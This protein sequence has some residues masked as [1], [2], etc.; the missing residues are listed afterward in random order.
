[1]GVL[2]LLAVL[3]QFADLRINLKFEIEVLCKALGIDLDKPELATGL[4]DRSAII[5][6]GPQLPEFAPGME[7]LLIG[8][9]DNSVPSA[10][11]WSQ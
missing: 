5:D 9:Y 4:R 3:Y 8:P 1:M 11:P 7:S 10:R 2:G 6:N